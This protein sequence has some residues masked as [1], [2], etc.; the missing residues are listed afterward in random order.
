MSQLRTFAEP[1]IFTAASSAAHCASQEKKSL[2]GFKTIY[3]ICSLKISAGKVACSHSIISLILMTNGSMNEPTARN[4]VV[5]RHHSDKCARSG[6]MAAAV[7]K[8]MRTTWTC[9]QKNF[10][11]LWSSLFLLL[12]CERRQSL[13]YSTNIDCFENPCNVLSSVSFHRWKI[14]HKKLHKW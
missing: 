4:G 8:Q 10:H 1:S 11:P 7:A 6:Q 5:L 14:N 3:S 12:K 9:A 2:N 13:S